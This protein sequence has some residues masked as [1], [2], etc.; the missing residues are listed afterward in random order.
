MIPDYRLK[1][2]YRQMDRECAFADMESRYD[3]DESEETE[4][5]IPTVADKVSPKPGGDV[6]KR[7][8]SQ[9]PQKF[10]DAGFTDD[11]IRDMRG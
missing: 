3:H 10:R 2:M 11:E 1:A 4:D 9:Y 7:V 8:G 5:E 6:A